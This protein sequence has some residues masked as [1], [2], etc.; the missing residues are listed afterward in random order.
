MSAPTHLRVR[1]YVDDVELDT[2]TVPIGGPLLELAD[3]HAEWSALCHREG[4][5]WHVLI[6]DPVVDVEVIRLEDTV[7]LDPLLFVLRL[8]EGMERLHLA[9]SGESR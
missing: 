6:D 1:R 2:A 7:M 4:I 5:R 9:Y 8:T 3:Q